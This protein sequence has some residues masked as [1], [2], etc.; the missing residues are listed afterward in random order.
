[1]KTL[2]WIGGVLIIAILTFFFVVV[3]F[4]GSNNV[5]FID[6]L[7]KWFG[8]KNEIVEEENINE[9]NEDIVVDMEKETITINE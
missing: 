5:S 9:T 1:M 8:N 6:Q 3:G 4:A 7:E 2:K